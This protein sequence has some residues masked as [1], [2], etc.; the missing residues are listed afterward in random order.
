MKAELL[1]Y[2]TFQKIRGRT[3]V[4]CA[5]LTA[6]ISSA[7]YSEINPLYYKD[8]T[9]PLPDGIYL[10]LFYC[11]FILIISSILFRARLSYRNL[12]GRLPEWSTIRH[13]SIFTIPLVLFS[14]SIFYIQYLISLPIFP[15]F[16]EWLIDEDLVT[17]VHP[18]NMKLI[19]ANIFSI[20]CL[21]II[22]PIFLEFFFRG[23]LLTRWSIK[24]STPKAIIFSSILFGILH[25]NILGAIFFGYV[26]AILYVKT[27]SLYVP[28]CIHILNNLSAV[29]IDYYSVIIHHTHS[30]IYHTH[31]EIYR[32]DTQ[33]PIWIWVDTQ[34][35]IWI[36]I[37]G[38]IIV[39]AALLNFLRKNFPNKDWVI[40]YLFH[41]NNEN[42]LS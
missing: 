7:I 36:W 39:V 12:F 37:I 24:W 32:V 26:L 29:S 19:I 15:D 4:W 20:F 34:T 23:I 41:H 2:F 6:I 18:S 13:Y 1:P 22:T 3:L 28:I 9:Y 33:T 38:L 16:A 11:V 27:K 5:V 10:I 8:I 35:P 21:T 17:V 31:S 25:S 40:P 14:F 30:E 42:N